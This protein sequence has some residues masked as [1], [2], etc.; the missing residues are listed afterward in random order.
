MEENLL[1]RQHLKNTFNV[2]FV[3]SKRKDGSHFLL[4][5]NKRNEIYSF[6]DIIKPYV[7]EIPCMKYKIAIEEKLIK[8]KND[9]ANRHKGKN[10]KSASK[11][12]Q[13]ISYSL[14]DESKIIEM[15]KQ[16]YPYTEIANTLNRT[17]YGLYDKV[18]RM[19]NEGKI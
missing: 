14:E 7:L 19:K 3:L 13:D 17:Y 4:S 11:Y 15:Y 8:S 16:G 6:I 5:I 9:Y 18:R 2:E 1:L 10:I 12:A